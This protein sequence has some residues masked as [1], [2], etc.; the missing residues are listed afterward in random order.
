MGAALLLAALACG[1]LRTERMPVVEDR[2][3]VIEH[4]TLYC[5]DGNVIFSQLIAWC[6]NREHS[7]YEVLGWK[8]WRPHH[9]VHAVESKNAIIWMDGAD[10][11]RLRFREYRRSHTQGHDPELFDRAILPPENRKGWGK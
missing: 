3:D 7:R 11:R 1:D 10:L 6:F 9:A 8:L 2:V 5:D 4:H